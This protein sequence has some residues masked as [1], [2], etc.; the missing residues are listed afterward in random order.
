[1]TLSLLTNVASLEAQ[2]NVNDTQS[3]LQQSVERLSSGLR[4]SHAS[5]DAAGLAISSRLVAQLGGLQ[6]ASRN[7]NDAVSM[8][9]TAEAGLADVNTLLTRMRE[10]AVESANGGTL[11]AS[12]RAS[13]NVEFSALQSEITRIVNVTSYNGQNL[14][15][16]SLSTGTSFQVG[17]FNTAS[18]RIAFSLA[19]ADAVTL[20]VNTG[21]TDVNTQLSSQNAIDLISSA[22]NVVS[23]TR[24]GIGAAEM[25]VAVTIDNLAS[26]YTNLAAANSRIADVDVAAETAALTKHSILLQ[27][28][29]SV[30]SQANQQPTAALS[31]L[32]K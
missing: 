12:D 3:Q 17:T 1:M 16:G 23:S 8:I 24:A 30:L 2:K 7:A 18:N 21:Q 26:V 15:D 32:G 6:Q 14:I 20:G 22:I 4:I 28:G 10:L 13:L 19:S 9:Q 5:D 29:I 31:L 27:A 11:G 25:R